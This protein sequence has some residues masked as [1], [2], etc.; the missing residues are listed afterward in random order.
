MK[1][2]FLKNALFFDGQK[3]VSNKILLLEGTKIKKWLSSLPDIP[4]GEVLN[5]T[6][7]LV[8]PG[9]VDLQ[10]NGGDS[11]YVTQCH[12][13]EEIERI[14]AIHK[15]HG[16]TSLLLTAITSPTK[17]LLELFQLI[18]SLQIEKR[19]DI[20]G[21]HLE[22]P[23]L[24]MEKRGA[25]SEKLLQKPD[26]SVLRELV[27]EG[28][29]IVKEMTV[30]PELFSVEELDYLFST[31]W[32]ISI[33]HSDASYETAFD[34][35]NRGG[36]VATHLFNAMS[37]MKTREPGVVGA[38]LSHPKVYAGVIADGN[39]CHKAS[40][41]IAGKLL[42]ERLFLVSDSSFLGPKDG[43]LT[44]DGNV[45]HL[46]DGKCL[47]SRGHLAGSSIALADAVKY[48]VNEI[49]LEPQKVL[50]MASSI[51][52]KV[53]GIDHLV[54]QLNP[55]YLA[56]IAVLNP[57]YSVSQVIYEGRIVE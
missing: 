18:R 52:A 46:V 57:D 47:D 49:G 39:H 2:T 53:M 34:F 25:H 42:G 20:L 35:L 54:G 50:R 17:D 29:G 13:G 56:N 8:V 23:F 37:Q 24:S 10:V 5:L 26:L 12:T 32:L 27:T 55:G 41:K 44:F 6:G 15:K 1:K 43:E 40:I 11:A 38:V 22:G 21:V 9:F 30:A 36:K 45:F 19:S 16:T 51:P 3:W 4:D 28:K 7:K 31:G 48:C 33:G 14:V